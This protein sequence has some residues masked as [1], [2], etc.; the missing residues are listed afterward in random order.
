MNNHKWHL[1]QLMHNTLIS[2]ISVNLLIFHTYF[3]TKT[4]NCLANRSYV[5][6]LLFQNQP[7]LLDNEATSNTT[8]KPRTRWLF[9]DGFG[10][11]WACVRPCGNVCVQAR[12]EYLLLSVQPYAVNNY[13]V[14]HGME[15]EQIWPQNS[16]KTFHPYTPKSNLPNVRQPRSLG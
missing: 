2:L 13:G 1:P 6:R 9:M 16:G 4:G 14:W 11:R 10:N 5:R 12:C 15:N 8:R 7:F 3:N